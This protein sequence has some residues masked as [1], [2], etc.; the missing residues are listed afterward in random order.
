MCRFTAKTNYKELADL[1]GTWLNVPRPD[2]VHATITYD[3]ATLIVN[4][5]ATSFAQIRKGLENNCYFGIPMSVCVEPAG[6]VVDKLQLILCTSYA[7]QDAGRDVDMANQA[8]CYM[9]KPIP[10]VIEF[11]IGT[12]GN[13]K[14]ASTILKNNVMG[15]HHS[16]FSPTTFQILEEFRKQGG[17]VAFA[18]SLTVQECKS[19]YAL[20]EDEFK[21]WVP[22]E[23]IACRPLFGKSTKYY[24]WNL[25]AKVWEMNT[26]FPSI[27]GD[28]KRLD[29]LRSFLRRIRVVE[30]KAAFSSDPTKTSVEGMVF[31]EDATLA[32][33]LDSAE[34]R[35]AYTKCY[36]HP[37]IEQH[38]AEQCRDI[39]LN[40]APEII[41]LR[42]ESWHRWPMV[43][44][45]HPMGS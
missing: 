7:G 23:R 35:L 30:M 13:A 10:P 11:Q 40:P 34:V 41:G 17:Q 26:T 29:Q 1:F 8:L 42:G 25:C 24:K 37:F 16:T 45:S 5:D 19:E 36:V 12:S 3:D 15:G 27:C 44:S 14:S 33:F 38:T 39:L 21:K 18:R 28:P 32:E 9:S 4:D 31:R 20:I 2:K 22:G 43:V 6:D